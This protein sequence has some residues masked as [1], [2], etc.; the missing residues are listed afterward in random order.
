MSFNY[1][2]SDFNSNTFVYSYTNF[3]SN[4]NPYASIALSIAFPIS[5]LNICARSFIYSYPNPDC[6]IIS[7]VCSF[8]KLNS[9]AVSDSTSSSDL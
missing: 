1:T 5:I 2:S 9:N 3:R 6:N 7:E 8:T 4:R